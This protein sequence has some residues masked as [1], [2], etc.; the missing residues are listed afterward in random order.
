MKLEDRCKI[1]TNCLPESDYRT[2]LENLHADLL[3]MIKDA[4][5]A[6]P[7]LAAVIAWLEN[8]CDPKEAA[9]ELKLYQSV[10]YQKTPNVANNRIARESDAK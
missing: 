8:G 10:M 9:K 7:N 3:E 4:L 6:R 2:R 5:A 1:A